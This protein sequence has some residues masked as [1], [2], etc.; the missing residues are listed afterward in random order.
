MNVQQ[1]MFGAKWQREGTEEGG[2]RLGW[3]IYNA[4]VASSVLNFLHLS[5]SFQYK[6][7]DGISLNIPLQPLHPSSRQP[8]FRIPPTAFHNGHSPSPSQ[9]AEGQQWYSDYRTTYGREA[10]SVNRYPI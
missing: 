3:K 9:T 4:Y 8:I 7:N 5:I 6:F 1:A 10:C 2:G